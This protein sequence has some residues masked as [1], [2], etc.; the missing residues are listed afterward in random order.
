MD[1]KRVNS[2][3]HFPISFYECFFCY[4]K[5]IWRPFCCQVILDILGHAI[6][7]FRGQGGPTLAR[8][9]RHVLFTLGPATLPRAHEVTRKMTVLRPQ[10]P[11]Q[12]RE[13]NTTER[14]TCLLF[15]W[16]RGQ[17]SPIRANSNKSQ[18]AHPLISSLHGIIMIPIASLGSQ[19]HHIDCCIIG[20]ANC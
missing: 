11:G 16:K 10:V 5:N 13:N 6:E 20:S 1:F 2:G 15:L 8:T 4:L 17:D 9:H 18:Y 3:L 12:D 7:V 19:R 14:L